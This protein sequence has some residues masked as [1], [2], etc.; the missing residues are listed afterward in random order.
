MKVEIADLTGVEC[1]DIAIT[2]AEGGIGYWSV[3]DE[4]DYK[5]WAEEDQG[6]EVADDF[7]FYTLEWEGREPAEEKAD[8]VDHRN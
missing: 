2:A 4:Y 6:I 5:R 3:I 7:V 8:G 1:G